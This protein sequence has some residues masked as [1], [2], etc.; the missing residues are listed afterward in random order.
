MSL[1]KGRLKR[2]FAAYAQMEAFNV[3]MVPALAIWIGWPRTLV[4]GLALA[5]TLVAVAGLLVVG[6]IYWRAVDRRLKLRDRA[7]FRRAMRFADQ[8]E[9]P[10]ITATAL[11]VI[12][13]IVVL[14][15]AGPSRSA[16]VTAVMCLLAVLE[17]VNYYHFQLQIFDNLP[18]FRRFVATGRLKKSHMARDLTAFRRKV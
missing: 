8:A 4:E 13:T 11:A 5:A 14:A 18:D 7:G 6:T 2:N 15:S 1:G 3:V 16:M 17:Y 9:R 12:M 10:M